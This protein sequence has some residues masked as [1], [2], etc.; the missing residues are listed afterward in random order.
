MLTLVL[1]SLVFAQSGGQ[2]STAASSTAPTPI[3]MTT[4]QMVL[5]KKGAGAP[6]ASADLQ[7]KMQEEHLARL[8]DLNRKRVNLLYGPILAPESPYAG[9]AVL[10]VK[11]ADEAARVFDDDPFVK[12]GVMTAEVHAWYGP[13]N[14]FRQPP[15][16]DTSNP[17]ALEPLVF[18]FLMRGGATSQDSATAQKIQEGHLAYMES[19]HARGKLPVAGPFGDDGAA[20][21]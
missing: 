17:A 5:L 6:P 1:L 11:T 13:K 3:E 19:L 9:I 12:A 18:G 14:W 21:G 10:D 16:Y 4:Y 8:A 2:S 7:K 15:T 20:R